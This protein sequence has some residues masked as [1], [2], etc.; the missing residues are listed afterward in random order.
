M[1]ALNPA[2]NDRIVASPVEK[3]GVPNSGQLEP[4]DGPT[5]GYWFFEG[6]CCNEPEPESIAR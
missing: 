2:P 5:E 3:F 6:S 1:A 4:A